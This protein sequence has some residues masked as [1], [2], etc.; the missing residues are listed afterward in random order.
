[1]TPEPCH[2]EGPTQLT[3]R[4]VLQLLAGVAASIGTGVALFLSRISFLG[5]VAKGEVA[6]IRPPGALSEDEFVGRCIRCNQCSD[7]CENDCITFVSGS[8]ADGT[9]HIRPR[10]QG[11]ILCMKCTQACPTGALQPIDADDTDAIREKVWMGTAVVDENICNSYNNLV[12][13]VCVWA[14]PFRG[15]A[16]KSG[17]WERPEVDPKECVGCGLCENRCIVYPKAMRVRPA[18]AIEEKGATKA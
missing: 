3:R 5:R 6:Y 7:V 1:M 18:S 16:L 2:N 13:G 10:E 12:C 9:P 15:K 8:I 4:T 14:C 11:C 17:M